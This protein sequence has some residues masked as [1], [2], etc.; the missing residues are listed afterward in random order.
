MRKQLFSGLL[1]VAFLAASAGAMSVQAASPLPAQASGIHVVGA[2]QDSK[3]IRS[4]LAMI[5]DLM[6]ASNAHDL[7]GV[8]KHYSPRFVSGDNLELREIK[9]LIQETWDL[10]PDIKYTTETLEIRLSGDWATVESIDESTATAKLD[11]VIS[12]QPGTLDSRS[13]GLLYLHRIGN[14]WEILSDYTLYEMA[15]IV[16]GNVDEARMELTSPEQVFS[17]ESY[18]AEVNLDVPQGVLAIASISQEPLVYPQ[19][20]PQDKF[21]SMTADRNSLERIFQANTSNNN[22]IVTATVGFTRIDQVDDHPTIKLNGIATVVKRVNVIPKSEYER[23]NLQAILIKT[24]A[25]GKV[26]LRNVPD[27]GEADEETGLTGEAEESE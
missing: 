14:T 4:I 24:S 22:E 19:V 6:A 1:T 9:N 23:D 2:E 5:E 12:D 21:R 18:S 16:Y 11:P 25:D 13:R 8:L 15:E 3:E 20:K 26:D 17:G 10:F 27:D 7:D